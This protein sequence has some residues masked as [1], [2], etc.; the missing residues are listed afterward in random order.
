MR[1]GYNPRVIESITERLR[2]IP[3]VAAIVLGGSRARGLADP[4]SDTDIGIYYH[5]AAPFAI[6]DV[7]AVAERIASHGTTPVVSE[8]YGWGPWVNGGAWIQTPAGKVDF[9]YRSL[10]QVQSVIEEGRRGI[11]RH[12][13][14]QQPPFGFRSVVYFG[15]THYCVPLHDPQGEVARLKESVAQYPDALRNRI[16]QDSL[17]QAEFSL[18]FCRNFS[19]ADDV[20][21]A[22]GCMTRIANCLV[23]A[24]FALNREYFLSDKYAT[25]LIAGFPLVPPDFTVRLGDTLSRLGAMPQELEKSTEALRT[26]LGEV[27]ELT[28]GLYTSRY[29]MLLG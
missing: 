26:L 28:A 27:V 22:A 13:F 10:E 5:D 17:W 20:Y 4:E 21:N 6:E 11:S 2:D 3:H 29:P 19:K 23:H 25:R 18:F 1:P 15:E 9:L 8:L 24:L 16:V 12:D 7:R 14:D